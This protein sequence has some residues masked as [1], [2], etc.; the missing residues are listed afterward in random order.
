MQKSEHLFFVA[1]LVFSSFLVCVFIFCFIFSKTHCTIV[2][3]T[4]GPTHE[5][6]SSAA[7]KSPSPVQNISVKSN[8]VG[9]KKP[10]AAKKPR[11]PR[12]KKAKKEAAKKDRQ[13]LVVK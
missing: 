9:K 2:D 6:E 7:P 11:A 1:S 5:A 10:P 4:N 13:P 3:L 8:P 12:Q